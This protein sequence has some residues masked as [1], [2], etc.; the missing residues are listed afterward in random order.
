[1]MVLL[2][3]KFLCNLLVKSNFLIDLVFFPNELTQ[4]IH[5]STSLFRFQHKFEK[6]SLFLLDDQN[7]SSNVIKC[8]GVE[9][10]KKERTQF[11]LLST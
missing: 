7:V 1:M 3:K 6:H 5:T 4:R 9:G 10:I 11:Y 2:L 8:D